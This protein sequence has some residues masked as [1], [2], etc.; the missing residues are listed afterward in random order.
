MNTLI[1]NLTEPEAQAML[2]ILDAAAKYKGLEL[3][4]PIAVIFQ[5][6]Q[7]EKTRLDKESSGV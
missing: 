6:L 4:I 3:S 1:L 5:K 7:L 2:Q